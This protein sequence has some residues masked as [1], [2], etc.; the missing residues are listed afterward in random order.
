MSRVGDAS[1]KILMV[2]HGF[3]PEFAGGTE[4]YALRLACALRDAGHEFI[5]P[6][7]PVDQMDN[8]NARHGVADADA[9][10]P[11]RVDDKARLLAQIEMDLEVSKRKKM[12]EQQQQVLWGWGSAHFA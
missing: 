8:P 11:H 10:D 6:P 4:L 3:P 7:P 1:L 9:P 5:I 12:R 2:V